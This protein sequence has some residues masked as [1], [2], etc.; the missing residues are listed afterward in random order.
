MVKSV[1]SASKNLI[2]SVKN[3]R[4]LMLVC[5]FAVMGFAVVVINY[6]QRKTL[7]RFTDVVSAYKEET[8]SELDA[9]QHGS[10]HKDCA[11]DTNGS[12]GHTHTE[13]AAK[14]LGW[15]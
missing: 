2:R 13:A 10:L 12:C 3:N 8:G 15:S 4:V 14:D 11:H 9:H 1:S 6:L 5:M 7:E